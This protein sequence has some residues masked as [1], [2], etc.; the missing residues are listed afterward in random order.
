[1]RPGQGARW[2]RRT[3]GTNPNP[4]IAGRVVYIASTMVTK[5]MNRLLYYLFYY[6]SVETFVV[7]RVYAVNIT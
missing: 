2:G 1:M 7:L 4:V 6:V 3:V 5:Q